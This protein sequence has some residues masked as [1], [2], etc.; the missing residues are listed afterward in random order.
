[1]RQNRIMM[2]L[3]LLGGVIICDAQTFNQKLAQLGIVKEE[4]QDWSNETTIEIPQP[5]CAYINITNIDAM[6]TTKTD[7]LN[8]DMEVY[9]CNGNYFKKRVVLNAQGQSSMSFDKK[10]FAVD[11]CEDDWIGD[12]TTNTSIGDWVTQD[13]YHFKAYYTD[14]FRGIATI[15]YKLYDQITADRGRIWT[16]AGLDNPDMKARCYPDGFPCIV[17]LNGEFYG[18]F[19]W[20]LKKHRKNFNMTK[21]V[22]EHIHLDGTLNNTTLFK[23]SIDWTQFEVRNPKSLYTMDGE[24][25]DGDNPKE[26]MDETSPYYDLDADKAKVKKNKQRTAQVKRFILTLSDLDAT[27]SAL[28]TNGA[29]QEEMRFKVE[30]YFDVPGLIDYCCFHF[31]VSHFDGFEKNWQWFTYDGVKWYVAPYDIDCILGN[32]F[33]GRMTVPAE[34]TGV[35]GG[36]YKS[37][38]TTGPIYWIKKYYF[39]DIKTRY[40]ELRANGVLTPENVKSIVENWYYRIGISNYQQEMMKWPDCPCYGETV[41]NAN[42]T[43]YDDWTGYNSIADYSSAKTYHSGD[44]C[45]LRYRIWTATGETTGVSP[46]SQLRHTDSMERIENWI[47]RRFELEDDYL[48]YTIPTESLTSYT[49]QVS[50]AGWATVCVPFAF[51]VPEGLTAYTVTGTQGENTSLEKETVA[52]MTEANKPY[53]VKGTPGFYQLIGYAE[54]ADESDEETYLVNRLMRGTYETKKVPMG[55]YVLQNQNGKIGFYPVNSED[56]TIMS[57]RAWL[58]LPESKSR[59][60]GLFF[61]EETTGTAKVETE[62]AAKLFTRYNTSGMQL[63]QPQKG[64]NIVRQENGKVTKV[65]EK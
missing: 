28:E 25:Y 20:Q 5:N 57:N 48:G 29:T 52:I 56:I 63:Q 42:W 27:L 6:P 41:C 22:A 26:L 30:E 45:K 62:S 50:N 64:L 2:L 49:L 31:V 3:M 39:E 44:K 54:D 23:G 47:D 65:M 32:M 9:D 16:R 58:V 7:D 53:L 24:E 60:T 14:W 40:S 37:L 8:A 12:N 17:Y 18:V 21:D 55:S 46:F 15:G 35:Y 51:T 1:M 4:Q 19:S 34:Y 36:T 38:Q 59:K 61:D 10:N 13:S 11:F 43:T 33:T